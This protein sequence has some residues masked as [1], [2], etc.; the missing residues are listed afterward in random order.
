MSIASSHFFRA[1]CAWLVGL[2]L[3]LSASEPTYR[4]TGDGWCELHGNWTNSPDCPGCLADAN[5]RA[6]PVYQPSPEEIARQQQEQREAQERAAAAQAAREKAEAEARVAQA[7]AATDAALE[8]GR[9]QAAALLNDQTWAQGH[10]GSQAGRELGEQLL[11][12]V[13]GQPGTDSA[14]GFAGE[15]EP[16]ISRGSKEAAPVSVAAP[17]NRTITG[18]PGAT[19]E[20]IASLKGG[21]PPEDRG[22]LTFTDKHEGDL[23]GG[24]KSK[25]GLAFG[26]SEETDSVDKRL[27]WDTQGNMAGAVGMKVPAPDGVVAGALVIP[28]DMMDDPDVKSMNRYKEEALQTAAAAKAAQ[29]AYDAEAKA[30][31][32]SEKLTMMLVEVKKTQE[33]DTSVSNTAKVYETAV[34][35]KI[36]LKKV[37]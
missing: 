21:K 3:V 18:N 27:G 24:K 7:K 16:L 25:P 17:P 5:R 36:T 32:K 4:M 33:H 35:K 8:R 6:V 13:G 20:F 14:L 26:P 31:P 28:K 2:S 15:Q 30:N 10:Q 11:K 29:S 22:T 12:G 19:L 37:E 34:Q 23:L 1:I 9:R